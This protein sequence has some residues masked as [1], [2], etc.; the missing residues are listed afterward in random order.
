M[1]WISSPLQVGCRIRGQRWGALW[2][3]IKS[4]CGKVICHCP[5]ASTDRGA[6]LAGNLT[7]LQ[8][9]PLLAAASQPPFG[10]TP[11]GTLYECQWESGHWRS[12]TR[13]TSGGS[14]R[15]SL[16]ALHPRCHSSGGCWKRSSDLESG[17]RWY[18]S[19]MPSGW[20]KCAR[21]SICLMRIDPYA[22]LRN[23]YRR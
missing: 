7:A 15:C 5:L 13:H 14:T 12:Y 2:F 6:Q 10:N 17:L 22:C 11:R 3:L 20:Q 16:R 9:R 1:L 19:E 4:P 8:L 21:P 23:D 18:V